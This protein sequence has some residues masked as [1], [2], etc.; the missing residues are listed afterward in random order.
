MLAEVKKAQ[1]ADREV[2]LQEEY[3]L[4]YPKLSPEEKASA[5]EVLKQAIQEGRVKGFRLVEPENPPDET[6]KETPDV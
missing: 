1:D 6:P 2:R 5:L 4:K 3:A